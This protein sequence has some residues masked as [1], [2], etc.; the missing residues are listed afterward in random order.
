M[1]LSNTASS[2]Y[3]RIA[4]ALILVISATFGILRYNAFQVGALVDDAHYVVLAESLAGGNGFRLLNFPDA[5]REWAFPPGWPLLLVPIAKLFPS[6]YQVYKLLSF[7]FWLASLVLMYKLFAGRIRSPN[8][9][10]LIALVALNSSLI[11]ISVSVMSEMAYLFFSLLALVVVERWNH[12]QENR[13]HKSRMLIVVVAV[14][15]VVVQLIRTAG[16]SLILALMAYLL[17]SRRYSQA[18]IVA[19]IFIIGILPQYGLYSQNG[20]SLISQGYQLQVFSGSIT[21]RIGHV[22]ANLRIYLNETIPNAIL[23]IFTPRIKS[24]FVDLGMGVVPALINTLL[25]ILMILGFALACRRPHLSEFYFLVYFLGILNFWNPEVG[26]AYR[27]FVIPVIP[28]FYFY[29]LQALAWFDRNMVGGRW[30]LAAVS[31]TGFVLLMASV[32]M[33]RNL[34]DWRDPVR[35]KMIDLSAGAD[36]IAENTPVDSIIMTVD[37]VPR[38]LYAHRRTVPYP[39]E[40]GNLEEY[41]MTN[42]IDYIL[43]SEKLNTFRTDELGDYVETV[44]LPALKSDPG[45]FAMI[46]ASAAEN[47]WVYEYNGD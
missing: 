20:G 45:T 13:K 6:N 15:A 47:V 1:Q 33:V 16:F 46:Y 25:L 41:I 35:E 38:Y 4:L 7:V 27:R 43:V 44:L 3:S 30:K 12:D 39:V 42:G 34:Q 31:T 19:V 5:P 10:F 18:G 37:P 40:G 2:L 8:L 21:E 14:L 36:W 11:G 23:P 24:A 28:F 26:P 17:L 22:W 9:E 29:M 32:S